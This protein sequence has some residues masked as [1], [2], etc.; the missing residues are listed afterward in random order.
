M[1]RSS[2]GPTGDLGSVTIY[3]TVRETLSTSP[4]L[5][6][7]DTQGRSVR[8]NVLEDFVVRTRTGYTTASKLKENDSLAIKAYR[9]FEG[10]YIAQTIRIR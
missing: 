1:R 10:N 5:V 8:I 3:G 4:Q 9:D 2:A 6:V 7:R